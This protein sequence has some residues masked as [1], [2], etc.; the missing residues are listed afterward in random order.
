[1]TVRRFVC[2]LFRTHSI[3]QSLANLHLLKPFAR[4]VTLQDAYEFLSC[5]L[6]KMRSLSVDLHQSAVDL[7]MTYTCPVNAHMA[8]Q[9]LSTRTCMGYELQDTYCYITNSLETP[10]VDYVHYSVLTCVFNAFNLN[11]SFNVQMWHAIQEH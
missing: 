2:F 11:C 3:V 4:C 8:F 10:D 1:M 7:G 5:V 6:T 9:M